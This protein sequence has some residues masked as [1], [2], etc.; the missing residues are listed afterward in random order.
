M[1]S[2]GTTL[3]PYEILSPLGAGGMG[4]VYRAKDTKLDREVAIKVLPAVFSRDAERLA[5][6]ERE[7]KLLAT[8][9]HSNIAAIY[10]FDDASGSRFL[11][12]EYV[13]GETLAQR[14]GRG[15]FAVD[16]A[17]EV[18]KQMAEALEVA[19]DK[20]VIHR[21]LKPGNVMIRE[22]GSVKVLDFG[23]AKV[24]AGEG[25]SSRTEI[26]NSPTITADYTRPGVV[27]GTAAYMSPEQARGKA[28]DR[29]TD[30]WSFGCVLYEMLAGV[31]PFDGS[32][33]SD[34][35][36]RIL[37]RDP[38]LEALPPNTPRKI[39]DL[40][41]RCLEKQ[42]RQRLRDIGDA[43]LEL[44]EAIATRSWT[45]S[46]IAA[47]SGPEYAGVTRRRIL[48]P[49]LWLTTGALV[50]V[51]A[52][53]ALRPSPTDSQNVGAAPRV[54]RMSVAV[55]EF[56]SYDS[57]RIAPD[58]SLLAATGRADLNSRQSTKKMIY[59]RPLNDYE[60]RPLEGTIGTRSF[61]FS[62]DSRWL[63]LAIEPP[64]QERRLL[65]SKVAVDGST[66]L[67]PLADIAP[68][69]AD[70][71]SEIPQ[72]VWTRNREILLTDQS[73]NRLVFVDTDSGS[74]RTSGP[75][76]TET[77]DPSI[78][79]WSDTETGATLFNV[80]S[81]ANGAWQMKVKAL[82]QGE[83]HLRTITPDG[84]NGVATTTG[85]LLY[86][87]GQRLLASPFDESTV[88]VTAGPVAMIDG[89]RTSNSW[90]NGVFSLSTTGT[91]VYAPG[92]RVGAQRRLTIVDEH[93]EMTDVA[94]PGR[95]MEA[96]VSASR[97]GKRAVVVI[98]STAGLYEL[99]IT[100]VDVPRLRRLA[101]EPDGDC[102]S[103]LWT[104]DHD[105][106]AYVFN[107]GNDRDGI[108]GRQA[109]G[110]GGADL[111]VLS[112]SPEVRL[113]PR[114]WSRDGRLLLV[115]R[116]EGGKASLYLL[117]I[118]ESGKP[119]TGELELLLGASFATDG[120]DLSPD[121]RWLVYGSDESSRMEIYVRSFRAD[122]ALGEPSPISMDGGRG[123]RWSPD[124]NSLYYWRSG[125]IMTLGIDPETARP[126]SS[127]SVAI[128]FE[129]L[130]VS[131]DDYSVLPNR[132][133]LMIRKGSD[134]ARPTHMNVVLN[135]FEELRTKA[136]IGG[137]R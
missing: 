66:A 6:F 48:A 22:D 37:E 121:G 86:S 131:E 57:I 52:T 45:T 122:G 63:A 2:A 136:P 35:I 117:R 53:A 46:A 83:S 19:H 34:V 90:E 103:S 65:L 4:E 41:R 18:A 113:M 130:P 91:L 99:W 87:R 94:L 79:A 54:T 97:D 71:I 134:E 21:D 70:D 74:V 59:V 61:S 3:G 36:A 7:A 100:D 119:S 10:G 20:G 69:W 39:I 43:L 64:D 23:L 38:D 15:A 29:R 27:L 137:R 80:S 110:T 128:D 67:L 115:E 96:S 109:D 129:L 30:I 1:L 82:V 108:Y 44:E 112:G 135:W 78:R 9:N 31:R 75:V 50:G 98:T 95:P 77:A 47:A 102:N 14:L 32:T 105:Y 124:G 55:P 58:G 24:M 118:D 101:S 123:P 68:E 56:I 133:L 28:L 11:V 73:A 116:M 5:R 62:P 120:A 26:A 125:R 25:P 17:I 76:E 126:T 13:K 81:Y 42:Q 114:A 104:W 89:L 40:I 106:I 8:L 132:E 60:F 16:E 33:T 84:S 85:H 72:F 93:G 111:L 107:G 51:L 88:S 12:M 127:P 49:G 92:G